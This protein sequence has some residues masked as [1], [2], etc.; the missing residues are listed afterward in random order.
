MSFSGPVAQDY[1]FLQTVR[2][3]DLAIPGPCAILSVNFKTETRITGPPSSPSQL[4]VA[5]IDGTA[6]GSSLLAPPC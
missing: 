6:A 2:I 3:V 4:T 1:R 5:S